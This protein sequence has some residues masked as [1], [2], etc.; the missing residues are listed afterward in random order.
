MH[1]YYCTPGD[2][3]KPKKPT[4]GYPGD[5]GWDLYCSRTQPV[6]PRSPVEIHTDLRIQLPDG[7]FGRIVGRSST[8]R[9]KGLIVQEAIIDNGWRGEMFIQVWNP[10]NQQLFVQQGDRIAQL[11]L[12]RIVNVEWVFSAQLADSLRGQRGFGSTGQ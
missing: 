4:K 11:L 3:G 12:H 7:Y 6:K 10:S 9:D 5:A 1:V 8:L 2:K